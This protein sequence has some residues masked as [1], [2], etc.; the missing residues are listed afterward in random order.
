[1]KKLIVAISL[2]ILSAACV[3]AGNKP[4]IRIFNNGGVKVIGNCTENGINYSEVRKMKSFNSI[5]CAGPYNVYYVQSGESKILVE[6][7]SES[8]AAL[9]T[10]QSGD[11]VRIRLKEGRYT[12][13]VLRVTVYSPELNNVSKSG[14]G[15]FVDES[16][17]KT[18]NDVA[19]SLSGSCKLIA[20]NIDCGDL[21]VR[22]SGSGHVNIGS[23]KCKGGSFHTSGSGHFD[24]G[25][26]VASEDVD[27][28]ISGSGSVDVNE[29]MINGDLDLRISGSGRMNINGEV[30]GIVD[31]ST[32]GSGNISGNLKTGGLET[33][34]S[35]SGTVRF[36][37]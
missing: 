33:S 7:N 17:H 34:I 14:S 8:V 13:L 22:I 35:G 36:T 1:M 10:E 29:T 25:K 4:G 12:S 28:H 6:G 24:F 26:F 23:A 15:N 16:G 3:F 20:D 19:Y 2:L 30:K 27:F 21:S 31:A 9:L 32:S 18:K 5:D 37:K 11:K